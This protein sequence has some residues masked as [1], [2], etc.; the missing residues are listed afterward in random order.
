M[1]WMLNYKMPKQINLMNLDVA[2]SHLKKETLIESQIGIFQILYIK[3]YILC[4]S[5]SAVCTRTS[6][7]L[8]FLQ[9]Q[10]RYKRLDTEGAHK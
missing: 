5:D 7:P 6:Q 9:L 4:L 10:S 1:M 2:C 8:S 3:Y